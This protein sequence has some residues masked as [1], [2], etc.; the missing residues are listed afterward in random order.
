[1]QDREGEKEKRR[2]SRGY[3]DVKP[4]ESIGSQKLCGDKE[5]GKD[6]AKNEYSAHPVG[7]FNHSPLVSLCLCI[8]HNSH[9]LYGSRPQ[10]GLEVI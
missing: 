2:A 8:A 3:L 6:Y 4:L 10:A 7:I 9:P 1:M 5:S